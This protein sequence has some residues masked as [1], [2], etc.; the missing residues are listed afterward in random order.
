MALINF[1][2]ILYCQKLSVLRSVRTNKPCIAKLTCYETSR[3]I[4]SNSIDLLQS[5]SEVNMTFVL[6][7]ILWHMILC[8][9]YGAQFIFECHQQIC[10]KSNYFGARYQV[11]FFSHCIFIY[12]PAVLC[13][14]EDIYLMFELCISAFH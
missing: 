12:F 5:A 7:L 4:G 8:C 13:V 2:K 3:L 14:A 1:N 11:Y 6:T 10:T 9:R